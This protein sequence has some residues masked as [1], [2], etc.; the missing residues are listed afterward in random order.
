MEYPESL[1]LLRY[2][3]VTTEMIDNSDFSTKC[4]NMIKYKEGQNLV[5]IP[6][7][8]MVKVVHVTDYHEDNDPNAFVVISLPDGDVRSIP[9][10]KQS[11][12][13]REGK[14]R[15]DLQKVVEKPEALQPVSQKPQSAPTKK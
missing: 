6:L 11:V 15:P 5:Y 2:C 14:P 4:N 1:F 9:V 10:A 8:V 12:Y 3:C 13:L 7:N